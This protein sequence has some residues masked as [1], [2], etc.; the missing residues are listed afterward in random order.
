MIVAVGSTG[1]SRRAPLRMALTGVTEVEIS[2]ADETGLVEGTVTL[3]GWPLAGERVYVTNERRNLAW[4]VSTDH[5]GGFLIDGLR[6]G[7]EIFVSA[8]GESRRVRVAEAIARVELEARSAAVRG[9]LLDAETGLP[10]VGMRVSAVPAGSSGVSSVTRSVRRQ[11]TTRTADDGS[12][13]IDGLFAVRYRLEVRPPGTDLSAET[14]VGSR[15]ST[16]P[17]ATWT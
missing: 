8:V 11:T 17:A 6:R 9:R 3:D 2:F 15:M 13:V 1:R 10:A 12:F 16:W 7:D 4:S 14:M 5:R